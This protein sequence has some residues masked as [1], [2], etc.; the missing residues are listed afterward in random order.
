M[1]EGWIGYILRMFWQWQNTKRPNGKS[2]P[3]MLASS[4]KQKQT[5]EV[6]AESIYIYGTGE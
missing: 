4:V 6:S 3:D 2:T 1:L 5:E